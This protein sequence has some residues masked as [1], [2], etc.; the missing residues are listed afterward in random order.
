MSNHFFYQC[1]NC[2]N[3]FT[4]EDIVYLC[5]ECNSSQ[6]ELPPKGVLKILYDYDGLRNKDIDF[7]SL[8]HTNFLD[9]LP[10]KS[11]DSLPPLRIGNTPLYPIN[12]IENEELPFN[13]YLKDDSQNPTFSFKDRASSLV[14]AFAK[15]HKIE[16][17]VTAST[18]NAGSSMAGICASQRQKAIVILPSSAPKAKL[19]QISMYGASIIPIKG[20]YDEAFDFSIKVSGNYRWYNRNTAYNPITIE[21]KKTVSFELYKQMNKT[22]PDRIFVPVGDG[23]IL[24]SVYKGYEDLLKLNIIQSIPTIVAVQ[25]IES[26]NLVRNLNSETFLSKHSRTMADSICVDFP[27]NFFMAKKYLNKYNGESTTVTDDAILEASKHL[28]YNTGIFSEPASAAAYAGFLKFR[29]ENKINTGSKNVVLLTG[30]G[31]KNIS[32]LMSFIQLPDPIEANIKDFE[33]LAFN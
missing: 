30:C 2:G 11:L 12:Q 32:S 23:V 7:E 29:H 3:E 4:T 19:V 18:G 22:L 9:L 21:G 15:E 31:L 27:R 5:P 17:I 14:S 6:R 10:I 16:T 25:S 24:A 28:S 20:N 1:I 26:D 13:L 8:N 33:K